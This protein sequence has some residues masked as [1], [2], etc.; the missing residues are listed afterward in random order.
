MRF[1][2]KHEAQYGPGH[3]GSRVGGCVSE[4]RMVRAGASQA[5]NTSDEV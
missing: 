3:T 1:G 5:A 2:S 4:E